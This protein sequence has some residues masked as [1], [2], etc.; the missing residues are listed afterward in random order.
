M[1]MT[2]RGKNNLVMPASTPEQEATPSPTLSTATA[3]DPAL[4][5]LR[6]FAQAVYP[7]VNHISNTA[8]T[9]EAISLLRVASHL[10]ARSPGSY[11]D[12]QF[13]NIRDRYCF[14]RILAEN[15]RYTYQNEY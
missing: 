1:W 11:F 14:L 2:H 10:S 4:F 6:F 3:A 7:T 15:D 12:G 9:I 8:L 5:N 13:Q